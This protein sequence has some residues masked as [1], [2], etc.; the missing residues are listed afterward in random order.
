MV[1]A[2]ELMRMGLHPVVLEASDR[3]GGRLYSKKLGNPGDGVI[4]ELGGMRF[5]VSAK[6]LFHYFEKVGV[7]ANMG[8]FQTPGR[9]PRSAPLST[10]WASHP[11]ITRPRATIFRS[12][13]ST[14]R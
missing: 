7:K 11:S 2:Y 13:P 9:K 3:I 12:L 8:I 10:T 4:C 5:P 1:C 14:P 6:A